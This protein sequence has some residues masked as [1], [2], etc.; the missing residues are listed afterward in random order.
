MKFTSKHLA[1]RYYRR[2]TDNRF[3][4][5]WK[6]IAKKMNVRLNAFEARLSKGKK[7]RENMRKEIAKQNMQVLK[8]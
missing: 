1:E 8:S 6:K 7:M 3:S 4:S 2:T 5:N